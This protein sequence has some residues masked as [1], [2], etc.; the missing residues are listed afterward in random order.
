[1]YETQKRAAYH[2]LAFCIPRI[3]LKIQ[4]QRKFGKS[5]L[6]KNPQ[7]TIPVFWGILLLYRIERE[8]TD[9]NSGSFFWNKSHLQYHVHSVCKSLQQFDTGVSCPFFQFTDFRL[10][11]PCL[12]R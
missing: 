12:F 5:D 8:R 1:M 6:R 9:S 2:F 4:L 10:G 3:L 11:N 7:D